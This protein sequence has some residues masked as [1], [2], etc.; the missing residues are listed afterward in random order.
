[1]AQ[2]FSWFVFIHLVGLVV[3]ALSHGVSMYMAFAV[4]MQRDPKSVA[5]VL[6]AG[7]IATGPMY[8]GL[9]LLIVGG[10]AAALSANLIGE[11]WII[12][13]IVVL[14]IVI[15]VMY[16]VATPY[17]GTLR[18]ALAE[19]GPDGQPTIAPDAL[20]ALLDTR[21]PEVLSAVGTVGLVI[22]VWLMVL[23]P[24]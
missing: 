11:P 1:M 19:V 20:A 8:I 2:F 3:F 13:S 10:L 22:L 12:A 14:V 16:S 18:K 7:Q 17:Y 6:A 5:A 24:G 15:A 9:V 4:R 21:R 23:R